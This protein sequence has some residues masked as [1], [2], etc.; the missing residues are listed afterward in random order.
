MT[1]DANII[2]RPRDRSNAFVAL[3]FYGKMI[4]WI[5]WKR[6]LAFYVPP[7]V[8][9]VASLFHLGALEVETVKKLHDMGGGKKS[10]QAWLFPEASPQKRGLCFVGTLSAT[11][12]IVQVRGLALVSTM[13]PWKFLATKAGWY[14][15]WT[16]KV[17]VDAEVSEGE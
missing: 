12:A 11:L 13:A 8:Y 7:Q 10:S 2:V 3:M 9:F 15:W 5:I 6:D 17:H 16:Q 1:L 14:L 4:Q